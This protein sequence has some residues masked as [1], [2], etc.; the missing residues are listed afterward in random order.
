[1]FSMREK[2]KM[3]DAERALSGR[4][5]P[6]TVPERHAVLGTPLTPPFPDG[7][8]QIVVAMGCF[9]GAEKVFWQAPAQVQALPPGSTSAT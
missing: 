8:E 9:W 4:D 7:L 1:M 5:Q 2:T 6:M 3:I